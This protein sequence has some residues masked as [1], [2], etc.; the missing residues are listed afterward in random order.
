MQYLPLPQT[1]LKVSQLCFGNF[2][3]GVN[4]WVDLTDE[5]AVQ[6]HLNCYD[7]G[8][9]FFDSAPAYGNGRAE[10]MLGRAIPKMGRD[11]VVIA[12]K[13]GYDFYKDPGEEGVHRERKQ[14]FSEKAIRFE[15]EQSLKRMKIDHVDLYQAHN[16]KL[17]QMTDELFGTLESL[18]G[19]GKILSYGVALGPAIG[20]R[21]EGYDSFQKYNSAVVQTVMNLYEQDPG[22][23]LCE[24][25]VAQ[26]K[27]GKPAG[28]IAR[29]PTNSGI[30]DEE[31]DSP[32]HQFGSND[33]RKFRDRHWLVYGLKKNN[34]VK[35]MAEELGC[36]LRQFAIKWLCQQPGIL[37]VEPNILSKQDAVEFAAAFDSPPL[38]DVMLKQLGEW[39]AD[40][41]GMGDEAH[42]CDHKSSTADQGSVRSAYLGPAVSV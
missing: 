29:V 19:E 28:V 31:F 13:F 10:D 40:D 37:A 30:L 41:F 32:N 27:A 33:H 42:P 25:A 36:S 12:T 23:E 21:E 15:V 8:V 1:D 35:P 11:N 2:T 18:V 20:W 17:P 9:N 16:L 5:Q 38:T 34:M 6:L 3:T 22:R 24:L 39:Y 14:D 4:W 26:E 7:A